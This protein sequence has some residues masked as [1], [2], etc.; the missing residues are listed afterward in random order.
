VITAIVMGIVG[1]LLVKALFLKDSHIMWDAAFGVVGGIA[2][3]Y[4][5]TSLTADVSKAVFALG[6]AVVVAGFLHEIWRRFGGH[7]A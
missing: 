4:L 2:A 6:T 7:T 1:G 3:Y 5:Y